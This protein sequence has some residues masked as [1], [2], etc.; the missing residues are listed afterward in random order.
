MNGDTVVYC[1]GLNW[2]GFDGGEG[3]GCRETLMVTGGDP[4]RR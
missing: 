3:V 1:A 2:M 4:L